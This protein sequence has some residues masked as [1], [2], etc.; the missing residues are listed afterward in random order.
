MRSPFRRTSG[1]SDNEYGRRHNRNRSAKAMGIVPE[2]KIRPRFEAHDCAEMKRFERIEAGLWLYPIGRGPKGCNAQ[3]SGPCRARPVSRWPRAARRRF[4]AADGDGAHVRAAGEVV[5]GAPHDDPCRQPAGGAAHRSPDRRPR[6]AG[7][8]GPD[9]VS[10][11][12]VSRPA[13]ERRVAGTPLAT[14]SRSPEAIVASASAN[15]FS[16]R[17]SPA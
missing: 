12:R 11:D 4:E 6:L 10:L 13:P 14:S 1:S 2:R 5:Q 7:V 17:R 15:G 3:A 16:T 8:D 9:A